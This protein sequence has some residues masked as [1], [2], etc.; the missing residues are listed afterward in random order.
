[1]LRLYGFP[2]LLTHA[3]IAQNMLHFGLIEKRRIEWTGSVQNKMGILE[4]AIKILDDGRTYPNY[5]ENLFQA[6]PRRYQKVIEIC[7]E[8]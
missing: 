4:R 7:L 8:N 2:F 1:V 6:Q 5:F 3:E